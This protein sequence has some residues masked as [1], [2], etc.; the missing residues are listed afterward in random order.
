MDTQSDLLELAEQQALSADESEVADARKV[1]L[2]PRLR[3]SAEVAWPPGVDAETTR[4]LLSHETLET[5]E[6]Q[7]KNLP[8]LAQANILAGKF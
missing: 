2:H 3:I 5:T 7:V 4:D 6:L 1:L 8:I